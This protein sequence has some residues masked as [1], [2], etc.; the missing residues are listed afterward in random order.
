MAAIEG[1]LARRRQNWRKAT[2]YMFLYGAGTVLT[3]SNK[4]TLPVRGAVL[5]A[6]VTW[7]KAG[8]ASLILCNPSPP[9]PLPAQSA[10]LGTGH[11]QGV[12]VRVKRGSVRLLYV[13][14][15]H[16][17]ANRYPGQKYLYRAS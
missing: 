2:A 14:R 13:H 6:R 7:L 1:F 17:S 8:C 4:V 10:G 16:V 11:N 3:I 5:E 15:D 12:G 9:W